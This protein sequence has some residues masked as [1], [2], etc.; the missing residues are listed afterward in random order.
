MRP[1]KEKVVKQEQ[2]QNKRKK[3]GDKKSKN[4]FEY[5]ME[6]DDNFLAD[7]GFKKDKFTSQAPFVSQEMGKTELIKT[8][9]NLESEHGPD[10]TSNVSVIRDP[11]EE[12]VEENDMEVFLMNASNAELGFLKMSLTNIK[13]AELEERKRDNHKHKN[14]ENDSEDEYKDDFEEIDEEIEVDEEDKDES[15]DESIEEDLD[16]EEDSSSGSDVERQMEK[17]RTQKERNDKVRQSTESEVKKRAISAKYQLSSQNKPSASKFQNIQAD[18]SMKSNVIEALREENK[19]IEQ[20][21]IERRLKADTK[22]SRPFSSINASP[23]K[24]SSKTRK[25]N[26]NPKIMDLNINYKVDE[27]S[28]NTDLDRYESEDKAS[29]YPKGSHPSTDA[30]MRKTDILKKIERLSDVQ[31]QQ[32][33][34]LLEQMEKGENLEKIDMKFLSPKPTM[35]KGHTIASK[36]L[37]SERAEKNEIRIRVLS[38]WGHMQLGG[39]TEIELFSNSG[40]KINLVPADIIIKNSNKIL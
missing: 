8:D 27:T 39:L 13:Q 10:Y 1:I 24:I 3:W 7:L 2:I 19:R 6:D 32:L 40:N 14:E 22:K 34:F 17:F 38:T 5:V 36:R 31:R 28:S 25:P 11:P 20:E 37:V 23:K 16:L 26:V 33:F 30:Q 15:G 29:V 12:D 9:S 4:A 21:E 18:K 35:A